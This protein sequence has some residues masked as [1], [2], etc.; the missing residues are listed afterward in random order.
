MCVSVDQTAHPLA[1]VIQPNPKGC[2]P[3][4]PSITIMTD[5]SPMGNTVSYINN[6]FPIETPLYI[7]M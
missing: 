4:I 1:V 5:E 6:N 2:I 3:V 7:A